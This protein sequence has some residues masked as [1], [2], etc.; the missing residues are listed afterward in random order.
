MRSGAVGLLSLVLGVGGFLLSPQDQTIVERWQSQIDKTG[1]LV[2]PAGAHVVTES[3]HVRPD[4][5]VRISAEPG[6]V[7]RY[8]GPDDSAFIWFDPHKGQTPWQGRLTIEGLTVEVKQSRESSVIR[9]IR[10]I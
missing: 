2:I 9:A 6:A 10:S 1:S 4:Q 8:Q 7:V 3:L 5:T